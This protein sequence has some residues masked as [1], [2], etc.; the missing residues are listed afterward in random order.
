M[1]VRRAP[2]TLCPISS[3]LSPSLTS[4]FWILLLLPFVLSLCCFVI[5]TRYLLCQRSPAPFPLLQPLPFFLPFLVFS[6]RRSPPGP[7]DISITTFV[8]NLLEFSHYHTSPHGD[9]S[10]A[11]NAAFLTSLRFPTLVNDSAEFLL[12][13][14]FVRVRRFIE[15]TARGKQ[16]VI[17]KTDAAKFSPRVSGMTPRVRVPRTVSPT[18]YFRS[19]LLPHLI[20]VLSSFF[21]SLPARPFAEA[22]YQVAR[23]WQPFYQNS[24]Q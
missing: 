6:S 2:A 23:T 8:A 22:K 17:I 20:R 21:P 19:P 4:L 14:W 7:T 1:A 16:R 5:S 3:P 15:R 9:V 11:A 12:D 10:T 24:R 18:D 13:R